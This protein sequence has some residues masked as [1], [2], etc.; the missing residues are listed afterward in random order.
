[1]SRV[2]SF[3]EPAAILFMRKRHFSG[4]NEPEGRA[5]TELN[6]FCNITTTNYEALQKQLMTT[7]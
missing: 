3:I 1:M 5:T 2:V 4:Q 7:N 6:K